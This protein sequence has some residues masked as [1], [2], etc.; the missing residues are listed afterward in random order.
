MKTQMKKL[1]PFL[2]CLSIVCGTLFGQGFDISPE[3]GLITT[4]FGVSDTVRIKLTS[5]PSS[6]VTI[7]VSLSD[8]TEGSIE[9]SQIVFSS[10]NWDTYQ[11]LVLTGVNDDLQD[12]DILYSLILDAAVSSDA[13]Y[14][15]LDPADL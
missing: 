10:S 1:Q 8:T 5:Q 4:E 9:S 12:G 3:S 13:D 15:G 2:F 14:S 7:G 11:P 6:D